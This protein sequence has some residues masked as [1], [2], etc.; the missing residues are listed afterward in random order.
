MNAA[1]GEPIRAAAQGRVFVADWKG[2]YG[3]TV[4]IDHGGGMATLYA[5]QSRAAVGY[6]QQV[7]TGDVIGYAGTTGI[8]TG[9]HLHFEVRLAGAPVDPA[10]YL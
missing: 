10:Q 4:M 3:I 9:C 1:C 6:G 2:G 7:S 5:H 8:S